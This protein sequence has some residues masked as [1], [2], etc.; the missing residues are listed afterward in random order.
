MAP[1]PKY[2]YAIGSGYDLPFGSLTN[3]ELIQDENGVYLYPPSSFGEYFPGS[4]ATRFD[5][6]EYERGRPSSNWPWA[7]KDGNG[8][9][10][11][12][13]A[14][15]I[16]DDYFNGN[17]SGSLTVYTPTDG[18]P[19]EYERVNAVGT[20]KKMPDSGANFKIFGRYG[21]KLTRI[22]AVSS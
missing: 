22:R 5:G 21:I 2:Q 11:Y 7:G 19:D 17:W 9:L 12:S 13:G 10:T 20:I 8:Y 18:N 16:R 15:T 3:V 1:T 14:K 6:L 4:P